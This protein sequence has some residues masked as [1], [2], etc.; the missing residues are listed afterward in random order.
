MKVVD[1]SRVGLCCLQSL[2]ELHKRRRT[3][4]EPECRYFIHQVA[5]ACAYLHRAQIIHRDLKLANLFLNDAMEIK[6]GD[7][8]LATRL[9]YHGER[10]LYASLCAYH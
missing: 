9:D 6:V 8:G 5:H 3:I 1:R 10:K 7:F 2:L 4:T